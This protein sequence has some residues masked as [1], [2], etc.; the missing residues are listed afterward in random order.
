MSSSPTS[1]TQGT[2]M[3]SEKQN[4]VDG[5][6]TTPNTSVPSVGSEA[7]SLLLKFKFVFG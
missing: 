4:G 7:S 1:S 5:G 3:E 6:K 2:D